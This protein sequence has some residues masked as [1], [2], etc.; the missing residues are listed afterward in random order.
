MDDHAFKA[1][2]R[3]IVNLTGAV[4]V[5]VG[6]AGRPSGEVYAVVMSVCDVGLYN[7]VIGLC[8]GSNLLTERNHFL[9]LT[10]KG[11]V[12][13]T[14]LRAEARLARMPKDKRSERP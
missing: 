9:A 8:V 10:D 3:K 1:F 12:L 11:K 6:D 5:A 14:E 7:E 13:L 4:V 2:R